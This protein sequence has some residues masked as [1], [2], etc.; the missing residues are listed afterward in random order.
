M[1]LEWL[2]FGRPSLVGL[3]TGMVAGLATIT[4]ASGSVGP[5]GALVIGL[6][7]GIVCF[8]AVRAIKIRIK[9]DDSLDVF[10]VHGVGGVLGVLLAP[11][12]AGFGPLAPGLAAGVTPI[13]QFGVQALGVLTVVAWSGAASFVILKVGGLLLRLRVPGEVEREGLDISVHG[14]RAYNLTP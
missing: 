7:A 13:H 3:V 14:E 8:F 9:I 2:R 6:S 1:I 12:L 11:W 10:A 4:P 5:A